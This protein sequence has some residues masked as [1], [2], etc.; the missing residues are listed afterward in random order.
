MKRVIAISVAFLAATALAQVGGGYELTWSTVDGGGAMFSTGG[1]Y[2]LGATV[3]Q[4][5]AGAVMTG[6]GFELTGGFWPAACMA[7][8]GS[9]DLDGDGDV[10]LDD[11]ALFEGCLNGPGPGYPPGCGA[12]DLNGDGVVDLLDFAAFQVLFAP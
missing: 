11:Y 7:L 9:G 6:G 8:P 5:D 10:D 2:E 1:G 12:A 4:P 3:G